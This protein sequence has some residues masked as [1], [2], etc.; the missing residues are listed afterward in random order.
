M[1]GRAMRLPDYLTR[2]C[3]VL[4]ALS[5][6]T[7]SGAAASTLK[8]SERS[9]VATLDDGSAAEQAFIFG[10]LAQGRDLTG[11]QT[12]RALRKTLQAATGPGGHALKVS[13]AQPP[14]PGRGIPGVIYIGLSTKEQLDLATYTSSHD[15]LQI[16]VPHTPI[17][18]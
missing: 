18:S 15:E 14:S 10:G 5:G 13:L 7:A 3:V 17:L 6:A 8:V 1:Y 9:A 16:I 11:W 2:S 4:V 12:G